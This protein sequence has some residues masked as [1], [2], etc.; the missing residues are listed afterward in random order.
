MEPT[1]ATTMRC[2]G[3]NSSISRAPIR[4][5]SSYSEMV[6]SEY[7]EKVGPPATQYLEKVISAAGRLDRLIQDVL[8]LG[9]ISQEEIG[10][11]RLDVE[12]LLR[13]IIQERPE[14]HTHGVE[15]MLK[16]PLLR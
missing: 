2:C 4:A 11:R 7:G 6:L 9:R 10:R 1:A 8:L 12:K 5:I 14:L 13:E 3:T 15:I 16:T